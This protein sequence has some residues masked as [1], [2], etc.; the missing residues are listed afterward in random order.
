[1]ELKKRSSPAEALSRMSEKDLVVLL[2]ISMEYPEDQWFIDLIIDE[3]KTREPDTA[4][5][6]INGTA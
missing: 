4:K 6:T 1:M 5:E 3:I 2:S